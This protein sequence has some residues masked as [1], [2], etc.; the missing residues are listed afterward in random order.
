MTASLH[1]A[2]AWYAG[3]DAALDQFTRISRTLHYRFDEGSLGRAWRTG[4]AVFVDTLTP[5]LDFTRDALAHQAGLCAGLVVPIAAGGNA[6]AL[7]FFSRQPRVADAEMLEALRTIALQI[8]Q[9]EQR[10]HAEEAL[11]YVASH[12]ALTGLSNRSSLQRD[13]ARAVKRSNRHQK[14]FAVMFVDI[15]RFKQINDSLGHGA[16]DAMIKACGE[17]L[18]KVLR[19]DDSVARFGGDEFVLVLENLSKASDAAIVAEKVLACCAEP[20]VIDERELHVSA[21]IGVSIYPEDGTDGEALLKNAD[22]AMYRA[23]DKGR[24]NYQFYAAQMNAQGTERLMLESGLRRAAER[25]ELEL[26]YQPKMSLATQGIVGVEA[27]MRWRHPVLGMVSPAQFIP[28]AEETGLIESMGRWAIEQACADA[29]DWQ[30][31]GLP[32]VQ[33]S[34]NLSPRQLNSRTLIAD[35][36]SALKATGLEAGLLELEITEGAM[37]T[38]RST[39][40]RCCSRSAT[41]AWASR[42]MTSAPAIRRCRT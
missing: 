35:I 24:G 42:S 4:E 40:S 38:T 41:W 33:M 27:L 8:G 25:G 10:K 18:S 36:A 5:K 1:C 13:L 21:S 7:E 32:A 30:E 26:H 16:G 6:T 2:A 28:I 19:E 23:K 15:D 29:R 20:F 12:D 3:D 22:T 14:R 17:R 9:Y 39:P 11:R 34:V 31:R 37:M